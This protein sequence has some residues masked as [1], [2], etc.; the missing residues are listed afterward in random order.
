MVALKKVADTHIISQI[1]HRPKTGSPYFSRQSLGPML[2][3][4][5][6]LQNRALSIAVRALTT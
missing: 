1:A 5:S 2:A 4:A 6:R 3:S